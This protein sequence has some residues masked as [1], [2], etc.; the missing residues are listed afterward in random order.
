[1]NSSFNSS[2]S[3]STV[4]GAGIGNLNPINKG[5]AL[6]YNATGLINQPGSGDRFGG[7][8]KIRTFGD[9]GASQSIDGLPTFMAQGGDG[10]YGDTIIPSIAVDRIGVLKGG[11]AEFLAI[12]D[13]SKP[14][15]IRNGEV[16]EIINTSLVGAFTVD[17][18]RTEMNSLQFGILG[19]S[20]RTEWPDRGR[21]RSVA[22]QI[23]F[24]N[25]YMTAAVSDSAT[26]DGSVG[27]EF[28]RT[29]TERDEIWD[30][31][32]NDF[33][34]KTGNAFTLD[35]NLTLTAG[36]RYTW[37]NNNIEYDGQEQPANLATDG[38]ASYQLGAS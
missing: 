12:G 13:S 22:N 35:G 15:I 32:F 38:V 33:S 7:S 34:V 23:V 24:L 21:D 4:D 27:A 37:L 1:M 30:N 14:D 18:R 5:D 9:W 2:R 17:H 31:E 28:K 16:N 3:S 25:H 10:G 11:R 36:A 8:T 6:R 29:H 20:S 19:T 26:Y